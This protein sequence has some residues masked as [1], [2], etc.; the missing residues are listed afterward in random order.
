MIRINRGWHSQGPVSYATTASQKLLE[1]EN[2]LDCSLG[3][4]PYGISKKVLEH[5]DDFDG[6]LIHHYPPSTEPLKKVLIKYWEPVASLGKDQ[7]FFAHGAIGALQMINRILVTQGIRVLGVCPQFTDY[8]YDVTKSGG[9]YTCV[10]LDPLDNYAF[11]LKQFL[12]AVTRDIQVIYLDNPN[13]PTGQV[14]GLEAIGQI[15]EKASGYKIPVVLDEA[16]GD[17]MRD[18]NSGVSLI[19]RYDNLLVVRSFSKAFGLAGLRVGYVVVPKALGGVFETAALPFPINAVGGYFTQFILQDREFVHQSAQKIAAS[20]K[21]V[22]KVL[23]NL[24]VL[25]THETLP[26]MT[27]M[28]PDEKI[29]LY[30]VFLEEGVLTGSCVPYEG[31]KANSVRLRIPKEMD[32]LLPVLERIDA[33]ILE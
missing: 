18:S 21:K 2:L 1:G 13:N 5:L 17:Y 33:K 8:A 28:A 25:A 32:I 24:K 16:Y 22:M 14:I 20:K 3:V 15:L 27:L 11:N 7:V 31:L 26:I 9:D 23:K 4:N 10:P 29:N 19:H 30:E 6:A 12:E